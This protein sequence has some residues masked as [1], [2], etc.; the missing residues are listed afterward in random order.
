MSRLILGVFWMTD[1][2]TDMF[3]V[4]A[5][6]VVLDAW[7]LRAYVATAGEDLVLVVQEDGPGGN[8]L[9]VR[10]ER[11]IGASS[12]DAINAAEQ[13]AHAARHWAD[14]MRVRAGDYRP[15]REPASGRRCPVPG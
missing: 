9:A 1:S 12:Q 5:T 6:D 8:G 11:G 2:S 15:L 10:V 7:G 13:I 4:P 3:T 14:L